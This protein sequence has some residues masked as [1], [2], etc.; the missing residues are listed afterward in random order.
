MSGAGAA[1]KRQTG[2]RGSS[3]NARPRLFPLQPAAKESSM[4]EQVAPSANTSPKAI[5][6]E[7]KAPP[8]TAAPALKSG[9]VRW[10]AGPAYVQS[11]AQMREAASALSSLGIKFLR[12]RSHW[13][14]AKE[15]DFQRHLES[16]L[17]VLTS[18]A[19]EFGLTAVSEIVSVRDVELTAKYLDF[20]EVLPEAASDFK[21]LRE[22]AQSGKTIILGRHPVMTVEH[23][24]SVVGFLEQSG[25][26][27]I[28]LVENCTRG[29]DPYSDTCLDLSMILSLKRET[30]HPVFVDCSRLMRQAADVEHFAVAA[31]AAG[32][33]GL[34]AELGQQTN[35]NPESLAPLHLRGIMQRTNALKYTL[36]ALEIHKLKNGK[37]PL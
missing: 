35:I 2:G 24:L 20:I 25:S 7:K 6:Q 37:R 19:N 30:K 18:A 36:D 3:R 8:S 13:P 11:V 16:G 34:L 12:S 17:R 28:Y 32:A 1:K 27:Q 15:R 26:S 33:D 4:L 9:K 22:L 21:L 31:V 23:F 5:P 14:N 10:M 29:F